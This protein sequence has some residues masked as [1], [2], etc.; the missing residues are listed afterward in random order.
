MIGELRSTITF[1]W[2]V[3]ICISILTVAVNARRHV[4]PFSPDGLESV[5]RE[6]DR[7]LSRRKCREPIEPF[8]IRHA[9]P[10]AHERS[11][12]DHDGDTGQNCSGAVGDRAVDGAGHGADRLAGARRRLQ[13]EAD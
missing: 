1:S 7:V 5:L 8:G 3:A 4:N 9:G 13:R 12:G 10:R 11:T 2:S 6:D